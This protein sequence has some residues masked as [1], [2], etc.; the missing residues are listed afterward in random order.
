MSRQ[1]W[2]QSGVQPGVL[3]SSQGTD[4]GLQLSQP[5]QLGKAGVEEARISSQERVAAGHAGVERVGREG[6]CRGLGG[7]AA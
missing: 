1:P 4:L 6:T 7:T 5:G 3:T 2:V